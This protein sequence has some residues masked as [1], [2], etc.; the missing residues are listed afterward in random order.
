MKKWVG[1]IVLLAF[2]ITTMPYVS[3]ADILQSNGLV[4]AA[5]GQKDTTAHKDCLGHDGLKKSTEKKSAS[6]KPC[7]DG[8]TCKC[9]GGLCNGVAKAFGLS[10]FILFSPQ[11]AKALFPFEQR[12]AFS[13]FP[14]Q[15][16][17]PP[18]A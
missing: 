5:L 12:V 3:H 15:I 11:S 4:T 6:G 7:C 2:V 8:K 9:I 14:F 1:F 17:R 18:R 13:D 16:K 10:S